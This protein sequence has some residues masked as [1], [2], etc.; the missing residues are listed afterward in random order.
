MRLVTDK[1]R[2][3]PEMCSGCLMCQLACSFAFTQSYNP[4]EAR[5]LIKEGDDDIAPFRISFAEECNN[6][7][8]CVKY[9][10][11]GALKIEKER[12]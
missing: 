5:I 4:V 2:T 8:L 12:Q 1:I 7:G 3:I 11:Y 6:C 10:F 9:C